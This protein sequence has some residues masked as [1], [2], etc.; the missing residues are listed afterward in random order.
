MSSSRSETFDSACSQVRNRIT[1][2]P[3]SLSRHPLHPLTEQRIK[4]NGPTSLR[5]D[6]ARLLEINAH[7]LFSKWF[8]ESGK[9]VQGLFS[10]LTEM[11]EEGNRFVVV[12]IGMCSLLQARRIV[13]EGL[14][15]LHSLDEVESLTAARA[16][17]MAGTEPSDGLRVCLTSPT[18]PPTALTGV[19]G[20][21]CAPDSTRQAQA[22]KERSCDGHEQ[23]S[24]GDW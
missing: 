19:T 5:Y 1:K 3:G 18:A 9:L 12:L 7:S 6:Q 20:C 13:V 10:S 21:K 11:I 4:I 2:H 8:S 22:Q 15:L 17:A 14:C 16:A 23:P 24:K